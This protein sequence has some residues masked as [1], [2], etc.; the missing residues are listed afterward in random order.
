MSCHHYDCYYSCCNY[1]GYCPSSSSGCYYYYDSTVSGAV[2][3]L[4]IGAIFLVCLY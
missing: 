1:Y 2:A 3:G 4:I